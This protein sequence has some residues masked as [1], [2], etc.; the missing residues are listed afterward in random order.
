MIILVMIHRLPPAPALCFLRPIFLMCPMP[1]LSPPDGGGAF[2]QLTFGICRDRKRIENDVIF[3]LC[4]HTHYDFQYPPN[5]AHHLL[6]ALHL[7][8]PGI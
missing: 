6:S 1:R 7:L 4:N 3:E 8:V 2:W 5:I